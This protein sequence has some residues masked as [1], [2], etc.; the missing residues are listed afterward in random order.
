MS[1]QIIWEA[2]FGVLFLPLQNLFRKK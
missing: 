2:F 1:G